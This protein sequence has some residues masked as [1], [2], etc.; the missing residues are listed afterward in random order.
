MLGL[1]PLNHEPKEICRHLTGPRRGSVPP[2][3]NRFDG[4]PNDEADIVGYRR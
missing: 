3:D 1:K 2:A 4:S